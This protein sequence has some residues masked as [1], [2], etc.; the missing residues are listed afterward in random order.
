MDMERLAPSVEALP[1]T[2]TAEGIVLPRLTVLLGAGASVHAGAPS[3]KRLTDL[4]STRG[5]G[6][7]ILAALE[8]AD[9]PTPP[10]FEDVLY[11]LEELEALD[12]QVTRTSGA[13]RPFVERTN[14]ARAIALDRAAIRAE[15]L[16]LIEAIGDAFGSVDCNSQWQPLTNLLRPMLEHFDIDIF[17]LNYDVLA[18]VA[19]N[20]LTQ[21]TGKKYLD[22]F[23]RP[24]DLEGNQSF[25]S[26]Q[27]ALWSKPVSLTLAH[28][29]GSLSFGY[30]A[31]DQRMAHAN[32]FEIV[33]TASPREGMNNWIQ[34]HRFVLQNPDFE[35]N[36]VAPIVA[37]LRKLDKLN[38]CPYAN[39]FHK[40]A[41]CVSSSP[42]MLVVGYGAGDP[43]INFWLREFAMIHVQE[44]RLV[45]ITDR[46]DPL[47]F[48]IERFASYDLGWEQQGSDLM[49][50]EHGAGVHALVYTAGLQ[51]DQSTPT[52]A[53][54]N[55]LRRE[56]PRSD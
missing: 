3:T 27:Y 35:F 10:T 54:L 25:R 37:G 28:V 14:L 18:D 53:F 5:I 17:T 38:V 42:N 45:E 34:M 13:L 11:V 29:H 47:E 2:A 41:Q 36:G 1:R 51:R 50:N 7:K 30:F 20:A 26:D 43:H 9:P 16:G 22:G 39:Y 15:R 44:A 12:A 48:V 56:T 8:D 24:V 23:G 4:V 19:V 49:S 55:F 40:F 21:T 31:S 52:A 33:Q 46:S 6:G 32:E